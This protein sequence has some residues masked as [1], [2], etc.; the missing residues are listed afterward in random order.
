MNNSSKATE[1]WFR[2][3]GRVSVSDHTT[4]MKQRGSSIWHLNLPIAPGFSLRES[5]AANI[6]RLE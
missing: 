5:L 1:Q 6:E 2:I 4:Y 3:C